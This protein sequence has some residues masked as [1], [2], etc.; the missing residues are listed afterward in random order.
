MS[1]IS[2]ERRGRMAGGGKRQEGVGGAFSLAALLA[3]VFGCWHFEMSRPFTTGGETYRACLGCGA[4]RSFDRERWEMKG[5]YYYA[6]PSTVLVE[7]R[8]R[9]ARSRALPAFARAA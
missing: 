2:F 4:R 9:P 5:D 3:R 1:V 6:A 8:A 7:P